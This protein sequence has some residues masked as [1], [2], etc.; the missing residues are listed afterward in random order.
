MIENNT[1]TSEDEFNY[2]FVQAGP[3]VSPEETDNLN[4][5]SY[6]VKI[7]WGKNLIH[8]GQINSNKSFTIGENLSCDYYFPTSQ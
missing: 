2:S 5:M 6:Q 8:L 4:A 1:L 3:E 7:F